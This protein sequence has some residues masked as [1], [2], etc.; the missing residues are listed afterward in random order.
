VFPGLPLCVLD[1]SVLFS[2]L[3]NTNLFESLR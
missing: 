2:P 1:V 3:A